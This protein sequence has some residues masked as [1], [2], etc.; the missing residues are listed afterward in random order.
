MKKPVLVI[1]GPTAVGKTALGIQV[2]RA[3]DGEILSADSMQIYRRMDIGTAKPSESEKGGIPHHMLDIAEPQEPWS[4]ARWTEAAVEAV[5]GIFSRGK[6]PVFVGGS[7]LYMD[8]LLRGLD[9][10]AIPGSSGVRERLSA[11]YDRLGGEVFRQKLAAVDPLRAEKLAP[12][13]KKRLVR[14]LEIFELTGETITEHDLRTQTRPPR[15]SSLRI[16]LSMR[17]RAA[18]YRRI[19]ER[20]DAMISAGLREEVHRLLAEGLSAKDTAM[21]AIGYKELAAVFTG[22]ASEEDAIET[23]KRES[24]RYAKR[25]LTWLRRDKG[26]HWL[27]R[28]DYPQPDALLSAVLSLWNTWQAEIPGSDSVSQNLC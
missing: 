8:S 26:L 5:E 12:A 2:A 18:L 19:D 21:Q 13:D 20:V 24:R 15:Y 1:S 9:F 10:S 6:L 4:V 7:G 25:Q 23:I 22:T 17:D 16:A 28:E 3:L 14:A 27:F 11:E